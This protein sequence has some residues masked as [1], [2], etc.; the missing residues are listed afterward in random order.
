MN[1]FEGLT[2]PYSTVVADPPW[3]PTLGAMWKTRFTDKARPQK[4]YGVMSLTDICTL[5]VSDLTRKQAHLWLW[6]VNQ[7]IDWG[8][9][10][11][12]AWGFEPQQMVTWCKPGMG[13][14]RFQANTEHMLV[15]RKGSRHGNPFGSTGGTWFQ[16]P[17]SRHSAKPAQSFDLIESVSPG[18]Y[19][20]L[21]AREPRLGWDSWGTGYEQGIVRAALDG[22]ITDE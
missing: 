6:V 1:V 17:R 3:E 20:E 7:H 5:P 21:F 19:V 2:P 16:W 13:T 15:C 11:A 22:G 4:H 8:Y 14:G 10:V 9:E 12:R 18:P